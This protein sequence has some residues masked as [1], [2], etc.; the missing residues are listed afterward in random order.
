MVE[1]KDGMD[2][3]GWMRDGIRGRKDRER[4]RQKEW[5]NER[6]RKV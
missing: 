4:L 5:S 1:V 2:R 3:K 6:E